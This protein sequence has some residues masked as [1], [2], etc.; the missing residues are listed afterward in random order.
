MLLYASLSKPEGQAHRG[1]T[2]CDRLFPG[3]ILSLTI[4]LLHGDVFSAAVPPGACC[5]HT[6]QIRPHRP[7]TAFHGQ[8]DTVVPWSGLKRSVK[9]IQSGGRITT[10]YPG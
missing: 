10:T 2:D 7:M 1:S 5:R 3:G 6:Y 4:G 8:A 9:L